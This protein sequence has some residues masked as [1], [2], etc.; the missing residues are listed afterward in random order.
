MTQT[1]TG[2][3]LNGLQRW[4]FADPRLKGIVGASH[5]IKQAS[6]EWPQQVADELG[7]KVDFLRSAGGRVR[8]VF[9]SRD[10]AVTFAQRLT[11]RYLKEIPQLSFSVAHVDFDTENL[12]DNLGS[13]TAQLG[14]VRRSLDNGLPFRGM[15]FTAT[16]AATGSP[17]STYDKK[18][19]NERIGNSVHLRRLAA[20]MASTE[21]HDSLSIEIDPELELQALGIQE[22]CPVPLDVSKLLPV[23][24]DR[25]GYI[26][27][28][29]MDGNSVGE[30]VKSVLVNNSGNPKEAFKAF[31]KAL[32]NATNIA[33]RNAANYTLLQLQDYIHDDAGKCNDHI[34][35][36]KLIQ[37]GDDVLIVCR[38]DIALSFTT[39]LLE[40]FENETE[41]NP[42]CGKLMAA[43]GIAIVKHKAPM[44]RAITLA[45]SLLKEAKAGGRQESR[46][47]AFLCSGGIPRDLESE[48]HANWTASTGHSLTC[49]P[50]TL[51]ETQK[52][53]E[54]ANAAVHLPRT[55]LRPA[56]D[57]CRKGP[58]LAD[59]MLVRLRETAARDIGGNREKAPLK[60]SIDLCWDASFFVDNRTNLLDL[61]EQF[62]FIPPARREPLGKLNFTEQS[63]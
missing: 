48:R 30:R 24:H 43:A 15:P 40:H 2:I 20:E 55:K 13:L 59:P 39:S 58:E 1:I 16:C 54:Q 14:A 52:F 36:R 12:Q 6:E 32:T 45:E 33:V 9:D 25:G 46:I 5:L 17:A 8:A 42:A 60:T 44:S 47:S 23:G 18:K 53:Q 56:C 3:D 21:G 29:A 11:A 7:I 28:I 19:R 26:A 4:I 50:R 31:C 35:F 51:E 10:N 27:V 49:W 62:Q 38:A 57:L 63:S 34:P 61:V 37:G 22:S 41:K